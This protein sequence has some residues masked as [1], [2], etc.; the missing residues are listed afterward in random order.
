MIASIG[1]DWAP[2]FR[3]DREQFHRFMKPSDE[4]EALFDCT[5]FG[6]GGSTDGQAETAEESDAQHRYC[7]CSVARR[8]VS[9]D[10]ISHGGLHP[11]AFDGNATLPMFADFVEE[12]GFLGGEFGA[13]LRETA[14]G[15]LCV[16]GARGGGRSAVGFDFLADGRILP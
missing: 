16:A 6:V 8:F 14:G 13:V 5:R 10:Q 11:S 7:K 3:R 2:S 1:W 9:L 4:W 12:L 15:D